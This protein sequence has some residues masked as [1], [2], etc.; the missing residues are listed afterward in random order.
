MNKNDQ[1]LGILENGIEKLKLNVAIISEIIDKNYRVAICKTENSSIKV[2]DQFELS[3]TYCSDV[4]KE[5]KTKY[6]KDVA[7]ITEM[8]KH[9]CYQNTQLRAYIGTP[10][11]INGV[12][13]GTLNYSSLSPHKESY[14]DEEVLFIESQ[15]KEIASI[16]NN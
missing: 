1:L 12:T 11:I 9:P 14:T 5:N 13:W 4:I 7:D 8:L 10:I 3:C 6:Y 2:G 16:L 15:A